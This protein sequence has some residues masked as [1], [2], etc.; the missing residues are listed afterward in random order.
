MRANKKKITDR[1]WDSA[2]NINDWIQLNSEGSR[3]YVRKN[4]LVVGAGN[5]IHLTKSNP[6]HVVYA[7]TPPLLLQ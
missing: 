4:L 5:K 7:A 1:N 2:F 3:L 6:K